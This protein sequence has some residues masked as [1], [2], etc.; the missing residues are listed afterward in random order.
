MFEMAAASQPPTGNITVLAEQNFYSTTRNYARP[1]RL[2]P[3]MLP[4]NLSC[5]NLNIYYMG[6]FQVKEE[7]TVIDNV[8]ALPF[9]HEQLYL[10]LSRRDIEAVM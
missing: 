1:L 7:E 6:K 8:F 2:A 10:A 3:E 9:W 5:A 4:C